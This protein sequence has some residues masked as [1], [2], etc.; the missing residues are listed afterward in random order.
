MA[1]SDQTQTYT[2]NLTADSTQQ[3]VDLLFPW[4][5]GDAPHRRKDLYTLKLK[6]NTGGSA[7]DVL[8][9]TENQTIP[10]FVGTINTSTLTEVF[11][12]ISD[13][14]G[15]CKIWQ[16]RLIG[17]VADFTLAELQFDFDFRPEPVSFVKV[18]LTEFGVISPN[19]KRIRT[20][21]VTL[22]N[23]V[24]T[25]DVSITPY[26]DGVAQTALTITG[27]PTYPKTVFYQFTADQWGTDFALAIHSCCAM[28]V[29]RV[30]P[31]IGVQILP[32]AKRFDQVGPEQFFRWG[33][34]Q[35]LVIRLIAFGGTSIPGTIY[36]EDNSKYPFTLTVVDG[37][38]GVYEVSVPKTVAGQIARV[39]LGPTA[40][41][42]HRYYI[43]AK[44]AKAG[45]DTENEWVQMDDN[46]SQGASQ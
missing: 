7:L 10:I 1:Y 5:D 13:I 44:V 11:L 15:V 36:F 31:P 34:I 17:I 8:I 41:D 38:E 25:E 27:G 16:L 19:K 3:L 21:P 30:H 29:Y 45:K 28:E 22:E 40:F 24:T 14:L 32:I 43:T 23:V 33:K 42:F 35:L 46:Y 20:W 4:M 18:N 2:Q 37:K 39:E 12:D 26:I 9:Q 6:I